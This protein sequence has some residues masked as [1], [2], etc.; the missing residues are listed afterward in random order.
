MILDSRF[1]IL[2]CGLKQHPERQKAKGKRQKAKGKRQKAKDAHR[3][4]PKGVEH[5]FPAFTFC[6]LPFAPP[7]MPNCV[8]HTYLG[9]GFPAIR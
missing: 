7:E 9:I 3:V 8:E 1:W 4:K 5:P 6:L 2:D